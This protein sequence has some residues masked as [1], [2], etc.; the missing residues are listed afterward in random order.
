MLA[1]NRPLRMSFLGL[2][3]YLDY[4]NYNAYVYDK[5]TK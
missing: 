5:T 3:A 4:E 2:R 1:L